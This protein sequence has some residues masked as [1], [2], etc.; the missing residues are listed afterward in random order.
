[1]PLVDEFDAARAQGHIEGLEEAERAAEE[2]LHTSAEC[3][4]WGRDDYSYAIEKFR[5]AIRATIARE[6]EQECHL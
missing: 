6:G 5:S 2:H 3:P 4:Q 1:V